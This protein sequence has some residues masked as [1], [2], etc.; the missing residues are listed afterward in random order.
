MHTTHT[1]PGVVDVSR[2]CFA[3]PAAPTTTPSSTSL[4]TSNGELQLPALRATL[5]S[6]L[7][8]RGLPAEVRP[9]S[10]ARPLATAV[11][12]STSSG[13]PVEVS[14]GC[15]TRPTVTDVALTTTPA[16]DVSA[17]VGRPGGLP[18]NVCIR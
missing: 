9:G 14:P 11:A 18:K 7:Q 12:V 3:P 16:R 10:C 2:Q 15:C 5:P 1:N 6:P 17:S 8:G 4:R 13:L